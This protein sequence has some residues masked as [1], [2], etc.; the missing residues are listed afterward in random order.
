MRSSSLRLSA[1]LTHSGSFSPSLRLPLILT[2]LPTRPPQHV[3]PKPLHLILSI[4]TLLLIFLLSPLHRPTLTCLLT[5]T[6]TT[7][8]ITITYYLMGLL[9]ADNPSSPTFFGASSI[10]LTNSIQTSNHFSTPKINARD[11]QRPHH[12][13]AAP[14]TPSAAAPC[15]LG[16]VSDSDCSVSLGC[17]SFPVNAHSGPPARPS[18][19]SNVSCTLQKLTSDPDI[20]AVPLDG[21]GVNKHVFGQTVVH[22]LEVAGVRSPRQDHSSL[23][24]GSPVRLMVEC[25]SSPG[26]PGEVR[27]HV[28]DRPPPQS[29]PATVTVQ[30]R[31]ATDE[32]FTSFHPE[33]HL[34]LSLLRGKPVFVELSLLDPPEPRLVLLVHSCLAYAAAP[35]TSWMLVYDGCPSRSDSQLLP[36]PL[37]DPHHIRRIVISGFLSLPS[38]SPSYMAEGGQSHLEDPEIYFLCLTEVCSAADGDCTVGCINSPNSDV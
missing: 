34:P 17:C 28:M 12:L 20:Y 10:S 1:D 3:L 2:P 23:Q 18:E 27:L 6:T 33:A 22:L 36:S 5:Q 29:P 24:E 30:L 21:C 15:S 37:S 13:Q 14:Y 7:L 16:P 26:S 4:L 25:S 9:G 38:E 19:D 35:Y 11:S 31:V 32:S 8:I